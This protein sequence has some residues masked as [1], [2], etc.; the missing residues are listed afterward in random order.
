MNFLVSG[1]AGD[2]GLGVCRILRKNF[3][4]CV[5]HGI[6]VHS[7][8]PAFFVADVCNIAPMASDAI[9]I[10][11]VQAYVENNKIDIFIPTSEAEISVI[12]QHSLGDS[13]SC[14]ILINNSVVTETCLDK[15]RCMDLLCRGSIPCPANGVVGLSIPD[16]FPVVVKP[17]KGQGSKNIAI[18]ENLCDLATYNSDYVWQEFL[19]RHEEEYTCAVFVSKVH[20]CQ[21]ILIMKRVLRGG[22]TDRGEVVRDPR[23]EKYVREISEFLDFDGCINVQLRMTSNG[24]LL[25]EINPRLSS[26]LVFRDIMG[27]SDLL[28]W[29]SLIQGNEI[30]EYTA[31]RDGL[32][33]Y[34]G[35]NEYVDL[36]NYYGK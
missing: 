3:P 36:G 25:F 18:I 14:K 15:A 26:T 2:I 12:N 1:V 33:F 22:F 34:R 21:R 4:E 11:W 5:I 35:V 16:K 27:F 13:V 17:R 6:D 9:Y 29:I 31:P 10:S 7:D 20:S 8:H 32:L 30:D 28:W 24:P 19:E 23:I